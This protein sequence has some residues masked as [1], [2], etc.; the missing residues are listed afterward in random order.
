MGD[1]SLRTQVRK[2]IRRVSVHSVNQMRWG[3]QQEGQSAVIRGIWEREF[4]DRC[5]ENV[6]SWGGGKNDSHIYDGVLEFYQDLRNRLEV[7]YPPAPEE[8]G[9]GDEE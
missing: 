9:G 5:L 1:D 6:W 2:G 3:R 8:Q 7:I 4:V